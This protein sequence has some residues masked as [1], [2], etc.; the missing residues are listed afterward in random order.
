MQ[1]SPT[2]N[3]T[4]S[5]TSPQVDLQSV[6]THEFGHALGLAHSPLSTAIMYYAYTSGTIKRDLT[7][8][9]IQAV[10][11]LYGAAGGG[12]TPTPSPSPSPTNTPTA[13][14]TPTK[15]PSPTPTQATPSPS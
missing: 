12:S 8:D 14:P 9:D 11:A 2:W 3:W 7:S 4:T 1:I 10:I 15:T 5:P 6:T 13:T